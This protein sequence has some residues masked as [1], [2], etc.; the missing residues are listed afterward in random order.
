[1]GNSIFRDLEQQVLSDALAD[2]EM[3][4][5]STGGGVV[6]R[7]ANRQ[8]LTQ[9]NCKVIYLAASVGTV[10]TRLR[11]NLGG[12]PSLSGADPIAEAAS[13]IKRR[14]PWYREV[15]DHIL[16]ASASRAEHLALLEQWLQ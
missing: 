9:S 12:R 14:D 8:A 16:D 7:A 11:R 3:S 6:E 15:A 5:I 4:I 2:Q 10:Q 1:M 13:M